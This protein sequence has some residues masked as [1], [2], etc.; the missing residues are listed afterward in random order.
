MKQTDQIKLNASALH[1]KLR[2]ATFTQRQV[3]GHTELVTL[4]TLME[5]GI[6]LPVAVVTAWKKLLPYYVDPQSNDYAQRVVSGE[7][8]AS[9]FVRQAAERFLGDLE[10]GWKRGLFYDSEA[11]HHVP[12]S[13]RLLNHSQ[14]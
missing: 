4:R 5:S 12:N 14:S 1:Q 6:A 9:K 10:D 13:F 8:L 11:A 2:R 3:H 7:I